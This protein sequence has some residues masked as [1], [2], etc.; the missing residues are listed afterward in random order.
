MKR[1]A[2][3][4][5]LLTLLL[6]ADI[7]DWVLFTLS[8]IFLIKANLGESLNSRTRTM[9]FFN[10]PRD[11]MQVSTLSAQLGLGSELVDWHW[12]ATSVSYGPLLIDS[13]P[14]TDDRLRYCTN[15]GSIP[16]N[17]YI[18]D[19]LKQSKLLDYE[20]TKSLYSPGVPIISPQMQ[21]S[22]PS[23][24]P[25]RVYPVSLQMHKKSPHL[26][27]AKRKK[28]SRGKILKRGSSIVS[29]KYNVEAKN[30]HSGVQ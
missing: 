14:R 21:K 7:V 4:K 9:F 28:T 29:K 11:K 8:T 3:Q 2:I 1:F 24:L 6:L 19:R 25:K 18:P 5:H 17:F 30:R 20:H 15:T 22:F 27:P 13:S 26:K 10:S 23:V 12:D 16:S